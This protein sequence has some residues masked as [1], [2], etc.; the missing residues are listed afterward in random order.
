MKTNKRIL[1]KE[2]I[3]QRLNECSEVLKKYGVR[4]IG[5]FGSYVRGEQ[6]E[7]SD[8]DLVVEFNLD[9]FGPE[10]KGLYEAYIKISDYLEDLFGKKVEILTPISIETIRIKGV[11]EEIK[12][13]IIYV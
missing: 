1:T 8:I 3:I 9:F 4:R 7:N 11:A 10:F 12:R 5:L 2:E 13:S 6:D